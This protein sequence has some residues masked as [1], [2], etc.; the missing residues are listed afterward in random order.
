LRRAGF[1]ETAFGV[2]IAQGTKLLA[3]HYPVME[4]G[5]NDPPRI[6]QPMQEPGQLP[7]LPPEPK[8]PPKPTPIPLDEPDKRDSKQKSRSDHSRG[9]ALDRRKPEDTEPD[10]PDLA[11]NIP[12]NPPAEP[13]ETDSNDDPQADASGDGDDEREDENEAV[14][15]T[16]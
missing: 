2:P 5:N 11:E 4:S 7:P 15:D 1:A 14:P 13:V 10:L 3:V 16:P 12:D 6:P 9:F 8:D